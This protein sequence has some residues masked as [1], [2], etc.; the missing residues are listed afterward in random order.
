MSNLKILVQNR[1]DKI[2]YSRFED[3][4][5]ISLG[6]FESKEYTSDKNV[7]INDFSWVN[8]NNV[9]EEETIYQ[10]TKKEFETNYKEIVITDISVKIEGVRHPLFYKAKFDKQI[11]KLIKL[12]RVSNDSESNV[13]NGYKIVDGVLYTNFKNKFNLE[14]KR[15]EIYRIA[16]QFVNGESYNGLLNLSK[17]FEEKTFENKGK[18]K[19]YIKSYSGEKYRYRIE[20]DSKA[21]TLSKLACGLEEGEA[22]FY[23]KPLEE[24]RLKINK[25]EK[26]YSDEE[27]VVEIVNGTASMVKD[28]EFYRY[29]LPEYKYQTFSPYAPLKRLLNKQ[30]QKVSRRVIK[31]PYR[32]IVNDNLINVRFEFFKDGE[33]VV[34]ED[35]EIVSVDEEEGFVEV[36]KD[37][38]DAYN[39]KSDFTYICKTVIL[40]NLNINPYYNKEALKTKYIIGVLPNRND[41]SIIV[42][43]CI[44]NKMQEHEY[45]DNS[46]GRGSIAGMSLEA[47][48]ESK[49][50]FGSGS[51]YVLGEVYFKDNSTL[52]ECLFFDKREKNFIRE[53]RLNEIFKANPKIQHTEYG[54]GEDGISYVRNNIRFLSVPKEYEENFNQ[55]SNSLV[56]LEIKS[57]FDQ[58]KFERNLRDFNLGETKLVIEYENWEPKY[59]VYLTKELAIKIEIEWEGPGEYLVKNKSGAT[60]VS[61]TSEDEPENRT[62]VFESELLRGNEINLIFNNQS[63]SSLVLP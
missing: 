56:G 43:K 26:K 27:W 13:E 44:E 52:S 40:K 49:T 15:Y 39:I 58:T 7:I 61:V 36:N 54:Y 1:P 45:Y 62:I 21:E 35:I 31:L 46:F 32:S 8:E 4:K 5:S 51:V 28:G 57:S 50:L 16:C 18:A 25:I 47:F 20:L 42:L 2:R 17:A 29:S 30:C 60:L 48:Y 9:F 3:E 38:E 14:T 24:S 11:S 63:S 59:K 22:P 23:W 12:T 34:D 33:A 53:E 55:D 6:Y 41:A 10:L 19:T 37:I